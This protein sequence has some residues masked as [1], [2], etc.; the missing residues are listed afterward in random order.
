MEFTGGYLF[1]LFEVRR[2]RRR[3]EGARR[4]RRARGWERLLPLL[5][6]VEH[7]LFLCC[8]WGMIREG[9]EELQNQAG[10]LGVWGALVGGT[11]P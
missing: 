8:C 7:V 5:E 9:N 4:A 11:E 10:R 2:R 3:G 1:H 6:L